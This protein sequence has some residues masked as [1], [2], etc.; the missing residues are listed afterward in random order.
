MA[1][2]HREVCYDPELGLEAYRLSGVVQDF[3]AHFHEYYVIGFLEDGARRM[4]CRDSV[5]DLGP[6]D[7][8][9]LNPRDSHR[10]APV[11]GTP[12]DYRAFNIRPEIMERLCA[13]VT[14]RPGLP[15]F[16]RNTV[17]GSDAACSLRSLYRM[18]AGRASRLEK[19]EALC[20]LLE[21]VLREHTVSLL[22]EAETASVPIQALCGY[23]EAHYQENITLDRLA[24]MTPFSKSYMLR[25][26]TRQVGVSPYRYLQTVRLNRARSFLERGIPPAEAAVMAG[27]SDQSHFTHFFKDF[28][29]LTPK[30]YQRIFPAPEKGRTPYGS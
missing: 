12:L 24:A 7:L 28:T 8:V 2:E 25:S 17:P 22:P 9:L 20:F 19:E 1:Q 15:R 13:G 27:F 16:T 30:Q 10:C 14:G 5:C 23:M 11:D 18:V 6:G 4:W 21:Q 3:P 29:G 26:F